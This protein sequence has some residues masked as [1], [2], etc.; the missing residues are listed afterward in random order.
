MII[1]GSGGEELP[2]FPLFGG[3]NAW[4]SGKFP[5]PWDHEREAIYGF[6][7]RSGF[8]VSGQELPDEDL[9]RS[10]TDISFVA[11]ALDGILGG[12]A[13]DADEVSKAILGHIRT[14][15]RQV[16]EA[17]LS[18]FYQSL[19]DHNALSMADVLMEDISNDQ[20]IDH[21][22]LRILFRWIARNAP[23]REAVKS[24][25]AV[26]GM[27]P[28]NADRDLFVLLGKHDE[29]TLFCAVALQNSL[30]NAEAELWNLAQSVDGWGRVQLVERLRDTADPEIKRWLVR[31][32][33]R[34]S[35][36]D[37]YLAYIAATTGD[38]VGQLNGR[39]DSEL[40]DGAAG[41]LIALIDGGPAEGIE[42]FD[43]APQAA[44]LFLQAVSG[45]EASCEQLLAAAKLRAFAGR[46]PQIFN[47]RPAGRM[48][49]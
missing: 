4:R 22:K 43:Q 23:D 33:F 5:K 29:F 21:E 32:G 45:R 17:N 3:S 9:I 10:K 25:I 15:L 27:F 35:I 7:S 16:D 38:L 36:M 20:S 40:L 18:V 1:A 8:S 12:T 2:I 30:G 34:N 6:L 13:D 44:S 28:G 26:L 42:D 39:L 14:V 47:P 11:G 46:W 37:E 31:G 49:I 19:V 41:I 48:R 24:S